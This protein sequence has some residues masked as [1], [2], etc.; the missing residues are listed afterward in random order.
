VGL[1]DRP[2]GEHDARTDPYQSVTTQVSLP[3]LKA[4]AKH[5]GVK[6]VGIVPE[7]ETL[8]T[9]SRTGAVRSVSTSTQDLLFPANAGTADTNVVNHGGAIASG[10]PVELVFWGSAWNT[11]ANSA[12]RAQ[13]VAALSGLIAGPYFSQLKQYGANRPSFRGAVTLV[14][15]GPPTNFDDGDVGDALWNMIDANVFPEPDDSGGR[16]F[17]CFFMPPGTNYKPGGALGAHSWPHDYDFPFDWDT[18][19]TAWVGF[20]SLNT[21][22]RVFGHELAETCSD[23]EGDGWYVNSDG[24]EIGDLCNSRQGF[25]RGVWVEGYWSRRHNACIIPTS[26]AAEVSPV[27]RMSDQLDLFVTGNDGR[28]Y[29]S[30][31]HEGSTWSGV[32]NNW[33]P[34]GGFFPVGTTVSAVARMSN[35]LDL[36]V[37][38]YDGRVYTSWWHQGQQ[39]SG[40]N[41]DWAPIGGF[42]PVG[43]RVNA[44]ARM[45]DQLDLFVIGNDGRVY[46]SWWHEGS[47]WSGINNNWASI[48]GFFPVGAS[49]NAVARMANHLDLFV[50]GNDGRVYTSWW[51]EGQ[52]WSGINDNWAPIGGFFPAGAT[53]SAL[54][55]ASDQ[56][57]LF[58]VGNDG[59]VY[60]SWWHEGS[61]WSGIN[62]NW[63]PIG[64][65]FPVGATVTAVAR[66]SNHLDLFVVGNDGRVYTSWWHEGQQWSGLHD[67]WA[68]IGGFFPPGSTVTA[69]A[70]ETDQLDLFVT[71]N[72][73]RVYTSWWHEGS[74]WSGINNNWA[75]I[76]GF[77]PVST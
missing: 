12:L 67:N 15:P 17:Y 39:W 32:N 64:G 48:G 42:F 70:R 41:D 25:V 66:M 1:L 11:P 7:V 34:I 10:V 77:F 33:A 26:V 9:F 38:G 54:A 35:H 71:G 61:N 50:I 28:V 73:G 60:T 13:V 6:R 37:M 52:Q 23:P 47:T 43:A 4:R 19:W 74:T 49:V 24:S 31:W 18:S 65:F 30:W 75:P 72:D 22:T 76:G 44:V 29:T 46:T 20:G 14:S 68:P 62:N 51:H 53:V 8:F 56:L 3:K 40:V 16:N 45:T 2:A 21:I 69:V 5:A 36:F 59:R 27:A 57:D 55:R 58:V 63:A